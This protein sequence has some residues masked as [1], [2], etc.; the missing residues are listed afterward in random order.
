MPFKLSPSTIHLFEECPRCFWLQFN[1]GIKRPDAIFPSLP[2]GIDN[3]L[4]KHF[5]FFLEKEKLPP[6]LKDLKDVKLFDDLE[7]LKVWR[8]AR[9]GLQFVD[10]KG[11]VLHGAID[12]LL[13]KGNKLIVL[14]YK[15]RGFP[16]KEDTVDH[17]KTQLDIYNFLLRKNNY[18]T[19]DYSYLLFY[20]SREVDIEGTILFDT[21]LVKVAVNIEHAENVLKNAINVLEG[22]LPKKNLDCNYCLY[23]S[24]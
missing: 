12:A 2:S 13:K 21:E 17:Y 18:L 14:D 5:D 16:L 10:E 4:K 20:V 24:S 19:E 23:R 9:K 8:N 15:T 11:N 1:K 7:L 3:I 6:A 22:D